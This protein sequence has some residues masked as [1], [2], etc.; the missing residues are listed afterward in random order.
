M[1]GDL[2]ILT[3][4]KNSIEQKKKNSIKKTGF[5]SVLKDYVTGSSA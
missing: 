2:K 4:I 5:A 3:L 1:V